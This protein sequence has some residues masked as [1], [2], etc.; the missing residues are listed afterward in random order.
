MKKSTFK[1]FDITIEKLKKS[2]SNVLGENYNVV[3]ESGINI[4]KLHDLAI[5]KAF[6]EN[7]FSADDIYVL[8]ASAHVLDQWGWYETGEKIEN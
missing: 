7:T 4:C 1:T 8:R 2:I 5:R 6:V 3:I